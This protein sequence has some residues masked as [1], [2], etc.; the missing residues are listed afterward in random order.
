MRL[1]VTGGA[2]FIGSNYVR[3]LLS[4]VPGSSALRSS[5]LGSSVV[6]SGFEMSGPPDAE[7]ECEIGSDSKK[8]G[9]VKSIVIYDSLTYAG[10]LDTLADILEDDRVTFVCGDICNQ[11]AVAEA[12]GECDTV[13]H[14]AA[15]SHVDRSIADPDVFVRT[16]CLGTSVVCDV[17]CDLNVDRFVHVSTDEVYGSIAQGSFTEKSPLQPTSPYA[18]SKA[19]SDLIAL[20]YYR[21]FGLNLTVT[22]SSNVFGFYQFPDKAIPLFITNLLNGKPIPLYGDGSNVRDWCYVYDNCAAI[23]TVLFS[24]KAGE[25]YNI[26]CSNEI[27]NRDLAE[28]LISLCRSDVD[29]VDR[30]ASARSASAT[31]SF[32]SE[33]MILTVDDRIGHDLR[34]SMDSSKVAEL[35][36]SP[37]H[38]LDESL[39]DTVAW[40]RNN[41]WWWEPRKHNH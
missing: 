8:V 28:R 15:E 16:N 2:G 3:W 13:V 9:I 19:A 25:I 20:S 29:L 26:S 7:L 32:D 35:G 34:Y 22:R 31:A 41:R 17:A 21:T 10:G 37:Q 1:F 5:T 30:L 12:M 6:D 33:R 40:Y 18:A 38:S 36:W 23:H 27:T 39:S 14:F 11:E 4:S 24:G